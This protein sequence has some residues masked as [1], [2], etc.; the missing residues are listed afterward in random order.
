MRPKNGRHIDI[1][2]RGPK[3]KNKATILK[4]FSKSVTL[5]SIMAVVAA[6]VVLPLP[7][8]QAAG[9]SVIFSDSFGNTNG[10]VDGYNGWTVTG[11]AAS[12]AQ[13]ISG[14]ANDTALSSS[15]TPKFAKIH[16]GYGI[17]HSV[18]AAGYANLVLKYF[19]RGDTNAEPQDFGIIEV[20]SAGNCAAGGFTQIGDH[21]VQGDNGWSTEQSIVIPADFNDSVFVLRFR[22]VSNADDEDFRIDDVS[23]TG[24][25]SAEIQIDQINGQSPPFDFSCE[26]PLSS[27]DIDLD[28]SGSSSAPPGLIE[29]Y[30]VQIDWGD[31]TADNGLG[32]FTPDSGQGDFIYAYSGSHTYASAGSYI[33]KARLY[34]SQPPGEDNQADVTT[35]L[36]ICIQI[37]DP[38]PTGTLQ[39]VKEV[40][41]TGG[42]TAQ[43]AD[44]NIEVTGG[45]AAPSSFPGDAAGTDVTIEA[46]EAYVVSETPTSTYETTYQGDCLGI[47]EEDAELVCTVK[48]TFIPPDVPPTNPGIITIC[49]ISLDAAGNISDGSEIPGT[50]FEIIGLDPA[51]TSVAPATDVLDSAEFT[52][53]LVLNNIILADSEEN[54]SECVTFD[55]LEIG[56]YYYS[57]E[58]ISEAGWLPPKYND[59]FTTL[60]AVLGDF[61]LYNDTLF[62]GDA[63]NDGLRNENADGHIILTE[64]RPERT[65]V[66]LNQVEEVEQQNNNGGGGNGGGPLPQNNDGNGGGG[67]GGGGGP[68]PGAVLD[69]TAVLEKVL[70]QQANES[71]LVTNSGVSSLGAGT[72]EIIFPAEV[73][74]VSGNPAP[75]DVTGNTVT[76]D[77][78][79][80][81]ASP[82][83]GNTFLVEFSVNPVSG[84][85]GAVSQATYKIGGNTMAFISATENIVEVAGAFTSGD[86]NAGG[87]TPPPQVEGATTLPRTGADPF[88]MFALFA[89]GAA[90]AAGLLENERK[91]RRARVKQI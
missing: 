34:H 56:S 69:F 14:A 47:M 65:M 7:V 55:D 22:N 8:S 16:D 58:S 44:F 79:A 49:K 27:L 80:L 31:L 75:A 52:T 32:L 40:D 38:A 64:E 73:S 39:V 57:E 15:P 67:G 63:S 86:Q 53:P 20:K 45:N 19:W 28:G 83:P 78:P 54:D 25:T 11:S 59:Q 24:E 89:F 42:G 60:I 46:G 76:W 17:C 18:D 23:V 74:F 91:R 4:G 26:N 43:V 2:R 5:V 82:G 3:R 6:L 68:S 81:S 88:I 35:S 21:S 62:D 41:N 1:Y 61:F 66:I 85:T 87:G 71:L 30:K 9:P 13:I 50:I 72:L 12:S 36:E 33:I 10:L 37:P 51:V 70:G 29:Q 90:K 84:G 77:V 48:N